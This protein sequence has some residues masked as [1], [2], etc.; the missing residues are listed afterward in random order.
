MIDLTENK[1][2]QV[3][4]TV[5]MTQVCV[6]LTQFLKNRMSGGANSDANTAE[7]K[8]LGFLVQAFATDFNLTEEQKSVVITQ[9]CE[10]INVMAA[11][12]LSELLGVNR[13]ATDGTSPVH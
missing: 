1:D 6:H 13:E 12:R 3:F 10:T 7:D 2:M 5:L 4:Q 11:K 9:C 8:L